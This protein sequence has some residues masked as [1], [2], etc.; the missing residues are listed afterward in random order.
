MDYKNLFDK[1][2]Q[3]RIILVSIITG[4]FIYYRKLDYYKSIPRNDLFTS[5]MIIIWS[6]ATLTEPLFLL[7]GL[8]LLNLFGYNHKINE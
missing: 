8:V 2:W 4:I 7:V 6:Y 5:V 1:L 3:H